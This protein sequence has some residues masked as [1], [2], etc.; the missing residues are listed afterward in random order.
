MSDDHE[1]CA[2]WGPL[3]LV[4]AADPLAV[5]GA[6]ATL[7]AGLPGGFMTPEA[8]SAAEI[9]IS[10]ALNNIV[11]HAYPDGPGQIALWLHQGQDGLICE[12]SD[13]GAPMPGGALPEG[14]L[15]Q[16]DTTDLPEG[17]FGWF[18]I[19]AL[20]DDVHYS[21]LGGTNRLRLVFPKRQCVERGAI[22]NTLA[23]MPR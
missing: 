19:R 23:T 1:A 5:R 3:H 16:L 11:E 4:F 9:V 20:T 8:R 2:R 10:E 22:I 21:R 15:P 12:I 17:G 14:R 18:M 6:V 7:L 13:Q